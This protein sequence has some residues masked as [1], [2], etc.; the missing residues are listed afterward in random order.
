MYDIYLDKNNNIKMFAKKINQEI[1]NVFKL[2]TIGEVL[3][4]KD[5]IAFVSGLSQVKVGEL[6][7]FSEELFGMALN[8]EHDR[9]GVVIF[10]DDKN[11]TQGQTV[12]GLSRLVDVS[13]GHHLLGRVCSALGQ[14][15]DG[16]SDDESHI[17]IRKNIERKAPGVITRLTVSEP[18][19]TG[20]KAIDSMLPIGRGQR[21]LIVGDRQTG[22]TTIAIDTI[23]NQKYN[24]VDDIDVYCV[25][26]GIGQKQSSILNLQKLLEKQDALRYTTI[27]SSTAAESASLQFI[28]PYTGCTI[29]EYFRDLGEAALIIYDD[30][31]KHAAAYRQLSLLL[32]RPPG[33][34]AFPGDIFYA[35]SRL[36]ERACKLNADFGLGSLTALPIVETQAGDLSG[37][38]P[39]NVISITDGQIFMEK[40][41]FFKG[42]RPAINVGSSVSRVGSKAQP[43]PMK[44]VSGSLRYELAQFREY[45]VFAQFDNDIDDVTRNILNRGNLITEILKQ[46]PH[47]PLELYKQVIIILAAAYGF[48]AKFVVDFKR[49][50][51]N[52]SLYEK[53]LY[54]FITTGEVYEYF[55]PLFNMYH[56]TDKDDFTFYTN[57]LVWVLNYYRLE[58]HK[59]LSLSN[60]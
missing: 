54:Q 13:V 43:Y 35:H 42:I 37:Y 6:V 18:L 15:I 9:I 27:I 30:L 41:L 10:G 32:R 44:L 39:T 46:A 57:P 21:E 28:A 11:V 49:D 8:L 31:T 3:T 24:N 53:N 7:Q 50:I 33:R 38:I 12:V 26:V 20:Y 59:T 25:Y 1:P 56:L 22:K 48:V 19:L 16:L 17:E 45:S 29:A 40:D 2:N 36:L 34:E 52:I 5:G 51:A 47:A 4:V 58:F 55:Q 14:P 60:K 23:L